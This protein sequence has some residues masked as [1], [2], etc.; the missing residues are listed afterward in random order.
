MDSSLLTNIQKLFSE[1]VDI[2]G[3]V[4]FSRTSVITG[5]VKIALKTLMECVRLK[6]FGKYGFQQLQ[7]GRRLN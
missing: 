4:E 5:I 2:F 6:T 1:R 7:V 3:P